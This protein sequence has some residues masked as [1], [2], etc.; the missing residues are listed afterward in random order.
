MLRILSDL[1]AA[2][3]SRGELRE[4][5]EVLADLK[6]SRMVLDAHK[7]AII[8]A[9]AARQGAGLAV[10]V[11]L[12]HIEEPA[13]WEGKGSWFNSGVTRPS[14][15]EWSQK[16]VYVG[17]TL[18]QAKHLRHLDEAT[19]HE[20]PPYTGVDALGRALL[21]PPCCVEFYRSMRSLAVQA[22]DDDYAPLVAPPGGAAAPWKCNYLGQYFGWSLIHHYPCRW[23]CAATIKR[24]DL[25]EE[26]LSTFG[27]YRP[28]IFRAHLAGIVI[29][30]SGTGVHMIKSTNP[31]QQFDFRPSA[32]V[33]TTYNGLAFKVR[34]ASNIRYISASEVLLD[35]Q[36]V[37]LDPDRGTIAMRF[38]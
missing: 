33:S 15:S 5:C 31:A 32:V 38:I 6:P 27:L 17:R 35:G 11:A 3:F 26:V 37:R 25:S 4:V 8:E 18:D 9:W 14:S 24:A 16:L 12:S 34:R 21:I 20:H 29:F 2:G 28:H 36:A 23:D 7:T 19:D 13:N 30:E 1:V 10:D 22:F